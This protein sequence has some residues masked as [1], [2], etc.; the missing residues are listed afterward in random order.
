MVGIVG[1]LGFD[2]SGGVA[3]STD[4]GVQSLRLVYCL[5]PVVFYGMALKL[6]WN[7]PLTPE[8]HARFRERLERRAVRFAAKANTS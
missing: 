4:I 7:Y 3:A 1:L 6:I 2:P 5:R 8:R